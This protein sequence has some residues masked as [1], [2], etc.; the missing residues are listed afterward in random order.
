[1]SLSTNC[2]SEI[3]TRKATGLPAKP[4]DDGAMVAELIALI[5]DAG[6]AARAHALRFFN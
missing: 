2:L 5:K 6:N 1:M 4:I 3:E